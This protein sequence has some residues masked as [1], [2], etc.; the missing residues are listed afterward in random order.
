MNLIL[1]D[2]LKQKKMFM[3]NYLKK[4]TWAGLIIII[5]TPA[6]NVKQKGDQ[7]DTE[8]V[9]EA[10]E[11]RKPKQVK[12]GEILA[13]ARETGRKIAGETQK[14]L[15]GNLK[16]AI[17]SNGIPAAIKYCNTA[18]Y[19]LTDSLSKLHDAT[20]KRVS[21]NNRNPAN[22]PD[23]VEEQLLE[24][25]HY[26]AEEGGELEENIQELKDDYLLYTKPIV[27][28]KSLCLNCHGKKGTEITAETQEI[29]E[30]LYPD[31]EATG[32][33]MGDLRGMWSIKLSRKKIIQSL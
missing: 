12:P 17:Q 9:K 7:V 27:V 11:A 31:D 6:C 28:K 32:Y 8:E 20:I 26:T 33:Q 3:D 10:I 22:A 5:L 24:A 18:A 1:L 13:Q 14:T 21:L 29:L 19:P 4:L 23:S 15:G 25:Y 30:N 2:N 16:K